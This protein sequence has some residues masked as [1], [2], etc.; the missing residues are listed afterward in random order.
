MIADLPAVAEVIPL[1]AMIDRTIE[2]EAGVLEDKG[3]TI[4]SHLRKWFS[5]NFNM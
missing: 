1:K 4:S 3:V 2:V 5:T